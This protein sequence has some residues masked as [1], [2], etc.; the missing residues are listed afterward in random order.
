MFPYDWTMLHQL[1]LRL[2]QHLLTQLRVIILIKH[3]PRYSCLTYH[4]S[5]QVTREWCCVKSCTLTTLTAC[6]DNGG[7]FGMETHAP[8]QVYSLPNIIVATLATSWITVFCAHRSAVVA[9]GNYTVVLHY[10]CT[11]GS[12]HAIWSCRSKFGHS[13]KVRVKYRSNMFIIIKLIVF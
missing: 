2:P 12:F 11:I 13:N 7:V 6:L 9:C 5:T 8:V 1:Y 10:N 3:Y 4:F